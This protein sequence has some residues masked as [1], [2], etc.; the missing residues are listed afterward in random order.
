MFLPGLG[1]LITTLFGNR[2]EEIGPA[3]APRARETPGGPE[4]VVYL[5]L[6]DESRDTEAK[7]F[8]GVRNAHVVPGHG[9]DSEMQGKMMS[10]DG[11]TALDLASEG[12]LTRFL[13]ETGVA[14]MRTDAD[15]NALETKEQA[16]DRLA[17]LQ[18]LF[19]GQVGEDGERTGGLPEDVRDE[20]AGLVQTLQRVEQGEMRMDRMVISGHSFGDS[21]W[22]GVSGNDVSFAQ[23]GELMAQFPQ[24]QS[25]VE[26]LMLSA[27]H[28]LENGDVVDNRDGQQYRDIF[29][30]LDSVWG[31]NGYS[32]NYEQGS[33]RHIRNW[34][35]ASAGN[36][37]NAVRRAARAQGGAATGKV[38]P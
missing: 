21:V 33:P 24:A 30:E 9:P 11:E 17:A 7:T 8:N 34:L 6:N 15:G 1:P 25:G 19:L 16:A 14:A 29:P 18:S 31:Y 4:G 27:C 32:P 12:D 20:M 2:E 28:T 37:P 23:F 26:D 10:T 5:G 38:F 36:D 35:R 22:S 3:T 13:R